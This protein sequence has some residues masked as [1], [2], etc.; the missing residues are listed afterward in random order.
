MSH[1]FGYVFIAGILGTLIIVLFFPRALHALLSG[2]F[3]N[4]K[5]SDLELDKLPRNSDREL[6]EMDLPPAV[7]WDKVDNAVDKPERPVDNG[8]GFMAWVMSGFGSNMPEPQKVTPPKVAT[9]E[10]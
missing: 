9:R 3:N 1:T 8:K 7:P 4:P 5:L 10:E 2:S 6:K